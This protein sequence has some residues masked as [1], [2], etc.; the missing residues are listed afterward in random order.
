MEA[1]TET[2]PHDGADDGVDRDGRHVSGVYPVFQRQDSLSKEPLAVRQAFAQRHRET[3]ESTRET[4]EAFGRRIA[5]AASCLAIGHPTAM[6]RPEAW[7]SHELLYERNRVPVKLSR[8]ALEAARARWGLWY[9]F[10]TAN[11]LRRQAISRWVKPFGPTQLCTFSEDLSSHIWGQQEQPRRNEWANRFGRLPAGPLF[12]HDIRAEVQGILLDLEREESTEGWRILREKVRDPQT[13]EIDRAHLAFLIDCELREE[14][15]RRQQF[16]G[17][18]DD[19]RRYQAG[20][21]LPDL[22]LDDVASLLLG[23][24]VGVRDDLLRKGIIVP[25]SDAHLESMSESNVETLKPVLGW[26]LVRVQGVGQDRRSRVGDDLLTIL[27]AVRR[28]D[29]SGMRSRRLAFAHQAV[30]TGP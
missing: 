20:E 30:S 16:E 11:H 4:I 1:V 23:V 10:F 21:R 6:L 19:L 29:G 28:W 9:R 17:R 27:A 26:S 3:S 14:H 13:N 15:A 12:L 24:A 2:V 18:R 22:E 8:P 25:A 7:N 5:V